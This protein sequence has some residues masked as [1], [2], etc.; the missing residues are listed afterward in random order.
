M[1]C[2]RCG[3][4]HLIVLLVALSL[5]CLPGCRPKPPEAGTGEAGL[6]PEPEPPAP[7]ETSTAEV[8]EVTWQLTSM[9]FANG[10]PIPAKYT[11]DG[12]DLSPPL[13]WGEPPEGTVELAL[14][15]DD[16][17]APAGTWTHWVLYGLSP[18]VRELPEGLPATETVAEPALKQGLN[19]WPSIGYRG[20]KPPPGKPHR[21]QFTLYAL[22][23]KL[24]LAPGATKEQ[25]L[26][27]AE[28]KVLAET[29]L[30]GTYGR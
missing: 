2:I 22:S 13:S 17:D 20:P 6:P 14:I 19:S 11:G 29:M 3:S 25:V 30:E 12:A 21:Y 9:A 27:A 15:C 24:D 18:E 4:S 28:G 8:P 16:P 5:L 10:E 1:P 26:E 23:E 7:E